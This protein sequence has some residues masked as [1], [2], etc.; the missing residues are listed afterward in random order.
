MQR[1]Q[2]SALART[3]EYHQGHPLASHDVQTDLLEGTHSAELHRHLLQLHDP[4]HHS[5]PASTGPAAR[6]P[7]ACRRSSATSRFSKPTTASST[8]PKAKASGK[9]PLLVSSA[10]AVVIT[11]V[12]PSML[13]PTIITAPT[14]ET[15]R[16]KAVTKVV[17]RAMRSSQ[18][19][20]RLRSKVPAPSDAHC[21]PCWRSTSSTT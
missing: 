16:P 4:C 21:S 10:I 19:S 12:K 8:S 6:V 17:T 5:P 18:A 7:S 2:Q 3:V 11:R 15:A 14:S 13:P 9:S 1:A 20:S